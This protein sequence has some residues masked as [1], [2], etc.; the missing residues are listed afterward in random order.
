MHIA[1]VG[2]RCS[3][4]TS[5]GR[6]LARRLGRS[7]VDLDEEIAQLFASERGLAQVPHAG[8]VLS[9]I[10]ESAFRDLEERALRSALARPEPSVIATGGGVVERAGNREL[11]GREAAVVWLRVDVAELQRR[12]RSATDPRPP[13]AGSDR[14]AEVPELAVRREPLYREIG[15]VE[16]ECGKLGVG[17]V[18]A[19]I[20][21]RLRETTGPEA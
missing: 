17:E 19:L 12:L 11:L 1:L 6:E 9:R 14:A 21:A 5:V 18:A 8:D 20:L 3:G 13:L 7:F 10:G 4:K 2:L 16:V 15:P